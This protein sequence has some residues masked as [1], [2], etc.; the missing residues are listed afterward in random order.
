VTEKRIVV[1]TGASRGIGYEAALALA[2]AGWHVVA[3]ARTQGGLEELDDAIRDVGGSA[4]LVPLDLADPAR[5]DELGAALNQRFGRVD[6][7][8]GNA[9][10]LGGG[11]APVGHIDPKKWDQAFAVNVTANYRLIRSLDPLLRQSPAGRCLFVSSA[12]AWKGAPF[13]GLYAASKAALNALVMAYAEE[14]KNFGIAVNLLNP[15]PLRTRMRAQ[16]MPGEDPDT[17]ATPADL[18]P[19]IVSILEASEG[20]SGALYDFPTL[21]WKKLQPPQ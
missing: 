11:L 20:R 12:A 15:G 3:I 21:S 8:F 10:L 5:I 6:A 13:W 19:H 14:V 7:L 16:A 2:R 17:L 9:G 4:S 18:A 1:V